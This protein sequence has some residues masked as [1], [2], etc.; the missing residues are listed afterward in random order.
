MCSVL[1]RMHHWC[2]MKVLL[3]FKNFVVSQVLKFANARQVTRILDL[4][5]ELR[6]LRCITRCL[7]V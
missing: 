5:L 2:Q 6:C 4:L 7:S 1:G 3:C